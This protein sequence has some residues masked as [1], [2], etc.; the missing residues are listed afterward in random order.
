MPYQFQTDSTGNP[1]E[2]AGDWERLFNRITNCIHQSLELPEI[3]MIA[4]QEVQS[5]LNTDRV[6]LYQ[7]HPDGSGEVI[8]ESIYRN[9]LPSLLGLNFPASDIPDHAREML[10]KTRQRVIVDVGSQKKTLNLLD[11]LQIGESLGIDD[12]RY[13]P[14]DACHIEY[15]GAMGVSSSLTVPILYQNQL[16]G[17]LVSHHTKARRYSEREL[18]IVQMLVDQ[19]SVAIAQSNLQ[20]QTR[21]QASHE[22]TVNQISCLL[23]CL[24]P[25]RENWQTIL[26]EVVKALQGSGGR[27]YISANAMER[28]AQLYTYGDQPT[29]PQIEQSPLWQQIIGSLK[30]DPILESA[31]DEEVV[32][33]WGEIAASTLQAEAD[34]QN[35]AFASH[36]SAH[37]P[38]TIVDLY[39]ESKFQSLVPA[40]ES[41]RI[42]SI[43]IVPLKYERQSV[44]CLSVFRQEIETETLWAGRARP[45]KRNSRPRLSFEAW[46]EIKTGQ[47]QA[48]SRSEI[49]LAQSLGKHLYVAIMQQRVD[50]TRQHQA[51]HDLLTNLP[52]RILF[53]E[54]LSLAIANVHE[55]GEMLA[56]VFLDIDRF[57]TINDTLGH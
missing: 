4:A 50:G 28:V 3:L 55:C 39:Q 26:A 1:L 12:I 5:F 21:Q 36:N 15:L 29:L 8:A 25:L 27:L 17:L 33:T 37:H 20:A 32:E 14:V 24:R 57:H 34:N 48:W 47:A 44:G 42:R 9:R 53:S 16:W 43:L 30:N 22:A 7:F 23:H 10:I 2:I 41:T 49:K 13:L 19:V 40:F 56:V 11:Y 51:S 18:R 6:K 52:N 38:Y 54:L 35:R 31:I 45:D 46:R